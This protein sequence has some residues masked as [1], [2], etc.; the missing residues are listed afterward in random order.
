MGVGGAIG[1]GK[2]RWEAIRPPPTT[3][4]DPPT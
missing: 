4:M 2:R 1:E 3:V